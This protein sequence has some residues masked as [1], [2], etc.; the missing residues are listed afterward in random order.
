M[1]HNRTLIVAASLLLLTSSTALSASGTAE[2]RAACKPDV[3]RLCK[4]AST[5]SAD[6]MVILFC[7][8]DNRAKLSKACRKVLEDN[9][10]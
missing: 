6:E 5:A 2:E 4:T 8:K 1:L 3:I 9:G 10:Q 7:L